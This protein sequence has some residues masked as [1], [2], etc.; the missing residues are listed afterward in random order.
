M[1]LMH[2]EKKDYS[3]SYK[4]MLLNSLNVTRP[5]VSEGDPQETIV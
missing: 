3:L 1:S 5:E 2:N 4:Q